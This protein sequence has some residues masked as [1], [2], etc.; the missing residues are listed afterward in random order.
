M[1]IEGFINLPTPILPLDHSI[2]LN[3]FCVHVIHLLGHNLQA[4][5]LYTCK[6]G[7]GRHFVNN[8]GL[9]ISHKESAMPD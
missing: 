1:K 7:I 3:T 6:Y 8:I 4:Y 9:P 2:I 5:S